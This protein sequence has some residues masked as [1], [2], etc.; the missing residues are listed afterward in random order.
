M[1]N[2]NV[3]KIA[4]FGAGGFG[5]EFAFLI[6]DINKKNYLWE[7]IGFFDDTKK[8]EIINDYKAYP[9]LTKVSYKIFVSCESN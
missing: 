6:E 7:I 9:I 1:K 8:D 4:L 5:R 3:K 2:S